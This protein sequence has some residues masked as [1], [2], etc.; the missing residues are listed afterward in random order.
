M[1]TVTA[2]R[3]AENKLAETSHPATLFC[4]DHNDR[5][6]AKEERAHPGSSSLPPSKRHVR[7]ADTHS[8]EMSVLRWKLERWIISKPESC[9]DDPDK[10][11]KD[12][13]CVGVDLVRSLTIAKKF[14][15]EIK[16]GTPKRNLRASQ[17]VSALEIIDFSSSPI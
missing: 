13:T 10:I 14:F 1:K 6:P 15:S 2:Q 7:G 3:T 9:C 12:T 4:V 11:L 5:S 17:D 16:E 8:S